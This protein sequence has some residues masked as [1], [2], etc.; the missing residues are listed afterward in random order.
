MNTKQITIKYPH[1]NTIS[2]IYDVIIIRDSIE[3]AVRKVFYMRPNDTRPDDLKEIDALPD[4]I[5]IQ[6]YNENVGIP[7]VSRGLFISSVY[8]DIE[9]E[10][11]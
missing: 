6:D 7:Y 8:E 11:K 5:I 3:G 10:T 9:K 2:V 4:N 1:E